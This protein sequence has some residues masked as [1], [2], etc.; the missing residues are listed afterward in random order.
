MGKFDAVR[1]GSDSMG[2]LSEFACPLHKFVADV[3]KRVLFI[4]GNILQITC[5]HRGGMSVEPTI[6]R[7][8]R[9]VIRSFMPV[10]IIL[11]LYLTT[12]FSMSNLTVHPASVSTR[13]PKREA[14]DN[15][16]TVCPTSVVGRPGIIIL[17]MYCRFDTRC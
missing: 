10:N 11:P 5:I 17:H 13:I 2:E 16:G 4:M 9:S 15:S 14:I 8:H 1:L 6:G 3:D 12:H 7:V